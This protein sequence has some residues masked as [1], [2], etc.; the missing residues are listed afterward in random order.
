M[1]SLNHN[2]KLAV[3]AVAE[4]CLILAGAGSGKTRIITSK[5]I[6]LIYHHKVHPSKVLA[7]TFT[8]KAAKE[9]RDRVNAV[10]PNHRDLFIKTFHSLGVYLLRNFIHYLPPYKSNFS[11][12]D[13]ED[14]KKI[15]KDLI[16]ENSPSDREV[17]MAHK[18]FSY[19][20]NDLIYE[21]DELNEKLLLYCNPKLFSFDVRAAFLN[22]I[23]YL[24]NTNLLDFDDLIGITLKLR[25]LKVF[26]EYI[27]RRWEY[28]LV[29]EYQ[30]TNISQDKLIDCFI[31]NGS[32]PTIVGDDHQSIYS[33]RGANFEN[34][35]TFTEKYPETKLIKLEENYRSKQG[36]LTLANQIIENNSTTYKKKLF[37]SLGEGEKPS[38][39][40]FKMDKDE[41]SWIAD[42]I[43]FLSKN[44][45]NLNE[46]AVFFRTNFQSRLI[47]EALIQHNLPYK[48]I[49]GMNFYQRKEVKNIIAFLKLILNPT[50]IASFS[51]VINFPPRGIGIKS[52]EKIL[53]HNKNYD[54]DFS[55]SL[56]EVDKIPL[57][58]K[59]K[60]GLMEF[61]TFFFSL[62]SKLESNLEKKENFSD[63]INFI[64]KKSGIEQYYLELPSEEREQSLGYLDELMN[65]LT[66]QYLNLSG[67]N[68]RENL[69]ELIEKISLLEETLEQKESQVVNCLTIH[70]AK[71]LEFSCVFIIGL[72]EGVFPHY[73][74]LED[75]D[76]VEEE[77]R[78]FYVGVTR[79]KEELHLS[80]SEFKLK[81]GR[82]E[83]HT[84]SRFIK[85]IPHELLERKTFSSL[86]REDF[87]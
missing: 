70:N 67:T 47:E 31:K 58:S 78:I 62:L 22:Y 39:Q 52:M 26:K 4:P 51:R 18:L 41:V 37:S 84:P 65:S 27:K 54:Y 21:E 49:G 43:A 30:D 33:F 75:N 45:F 82:L 61:S 44:K 59:A 32:I 12:L 29:D 13:E 40:S 66:D 71:G 63:F 72:E 81:S 17:K 56:K 85:E 42:K 9:M 38:Y 5:I 36:I 23:E 74:S 6:N 55:L 53:D 28:L 24:K 14:R 57:T 79:A 48:I 20:K 60:I 68:L 1:L 3:E 64:F 87:F 15:I 10:I 86:D 50:D 35:F 8:N 34:I 46:I 69:S 19:L 2:Q 77:R 25:K 73:L 76:Q 16:S 7:I 83:F 80:S 11:I